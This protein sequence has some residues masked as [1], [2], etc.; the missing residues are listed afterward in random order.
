ME[1]CDK[2]GALMLPKKGEKKTVLKCRECGRE[3][4]VKEAPDYTVDYRVHHSPSEKIVVVEDENPDEEELTEDERRE[5]RKEIL[6]FY[7]D[8]ETE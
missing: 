1:F 4:T 3:R 6:E 7:E 8:E 2:C 5:K